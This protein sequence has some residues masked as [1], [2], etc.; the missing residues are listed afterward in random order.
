MGGADSHAY[1]PG[2]A[3]R[4]R[5]CPPGRAA[6]GS[7]ALFPRRS[8]P[9]RDA[10]SRAH[11]DPHVPRHRDPCSSCDD[12]KSQGMATAPS[13]PGA[14]ASPLLAAAPR[15]HAAARQDGR[16]AGRGSRHRGPR[17][18]RDRVLRAGARCVHCRAGH[19]PLPA[20]VQPLIERR[21]HGVAAGAGSGGGRRADRPRRRAPAQ[22]AVGAGAA[23]PVVADVRGSGRAALRPARTRIPPR[24]SGG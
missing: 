14:G 7:R 4:P 13:G 15:E 8:R 24:D 21:P 22:G 5:V 23:A 17:A 20:R 11:P 10:G 3:V 18:Q 19:R 6:Q 1:R 12:S 16:R 2:G 9:R